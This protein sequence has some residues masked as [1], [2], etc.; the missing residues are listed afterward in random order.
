MDTRCSTYLEDIAAMAFGEEEVAGR[1]HILGCTDCSAKLA[2]MRKTI[3]RGSMATFT[4]PADVLERAKS[5][6]PGTARRSIL[7][8]LV[9]NSLAAAGARSTTADTF[10]LAFEAEDTKARLMFTKG[11]SGWDVIGEITPG[12]KQVTTGGK[13]VKLDQS[14]RFQFHAKSLDATEMLVTR[15]DREITIPS[16]QEILEGGS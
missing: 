2:Q 5:L 10:Q 14:G 3:E 13:P 6:M 8:T 11:A 7:A 12:S 1:Q 4:P 15:D 16:A 9:G